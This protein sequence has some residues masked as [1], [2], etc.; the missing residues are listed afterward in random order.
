MLQKSVSNDAYAKYLLRIS[1]RVIQTGTV[2]YFRE[3]QDT[4]E[5][6]YFRLIYH[7]IIYRT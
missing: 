6:F 5:A 3:V 2:S 7:Q 1:Y 4:R